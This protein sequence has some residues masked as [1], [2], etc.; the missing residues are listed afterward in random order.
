MFGAAVSRFLNKGNGFVEL[1]GIVEG[2]GICDHLGSSLSA[3]YLDYLGVAL[4]AEQC[5]K[6]LLY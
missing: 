5:Q 4:F 3:A 2:C 6:Q 1:T